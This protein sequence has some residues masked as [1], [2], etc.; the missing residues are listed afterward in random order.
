MKITAA[1]YAKA[2]AGVV[3]LGIQFAQWKY[4]TGNE[5]VIAA[6]AAAS[7]LG[8]YAIPNAPKPAPA[9]PSNVTITRPPA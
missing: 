9:Q 1:Q 2:I 6:V 7:A 3:G 4:G 5:W 8:I